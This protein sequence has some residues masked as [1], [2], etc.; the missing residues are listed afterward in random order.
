[1]KLFIQQVLNGAGVGSQYA[2]WAVGYGLVYQVLGLMHFAH[3]DVLALSLFVFFTLLVTH[4]FPILLGIVGVLAVGALLSSCVWYTSYKPLVV[5]GQA[6]GAFTAALGASLVLRNIIDR[7]WGP[8]TRAFPDI[9]PSKVFDVAGVKISIVPLL[10]LAIALVVVVA[11]QQFLARSRHGQGIVALAQDRGAAALMGINVGLATAGVYAL[12]GLIGM[13]GG[14]L[15]IANFHAVTASVG[16]T[17]TLKAF[18]AAIL[19]GFGRLEG[20][21]IGGLLLGVGES[22]L[23]SNVTTTYRDALVFTI[24]IALLVFRPHGLLGRPVPVK[25]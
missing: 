6:S 11:F 25:V 9:I 1:V 18:I 17:I 15:F 14:V 5:R 2:L 20:A 21:V 12:S 23:A 10:S 22:L 8:G 3:G 7:V 4:S 24:L 13:A 19:G 16:F